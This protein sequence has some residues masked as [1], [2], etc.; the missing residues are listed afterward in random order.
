M[1]LRATHFE[2][3]VFI[4][5]GK[6]KY[7]PY[8]L[9][10]LAQVSPINSIVVKDINDDHNLDLIIAGNNYNT[11]VETPRYDAG[12]GLLLLGDGSGQ[13]NPITSLESGFFVQEN[14]RDMALIKGQTN[15][16]L[17]GVAVNNEK[18]KFYKKQDK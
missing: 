1:H 18:M 17:I 13:F 12:T 3:T 15:N 6:G 9:P 10:S 11:E 7:K 14:V 8:P 4:N 5:Q 2:S 16:Y